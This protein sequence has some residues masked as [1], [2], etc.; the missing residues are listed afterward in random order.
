MQ[1]SQT[2][3]ITVD[4][5][6][7]LLGPDARVSP[8]NLAALQAAAAAG[9][10][11]VVATGRR[12]TYALHVLREIGMPVQTVM[13]TSNGAVVRTLAGAPIERT[14]MPNETARWLCGHIGEFR[15]ALVITFDKLLPDGEDAKGSL[16]VEELEDL[17]ASIGNWIRSNERYL[18]RV[19]P[20]EDALNGDPPIQMML[21][22]TVERMRRAELRMLED[23]RIHAVGETRPDSL[24]TLNRT[25][26]ADRDLSLLDILPAGCSKGNALL[27]L[28]ASHNIAPHEIMAIGDNYN[29]LS[30]LE[31]VGRPVLMGNAP[32]DLQ[33]VALQR[34]W[35]ITASNEIDGVA[36][37][38][39]ETFP[40]LDP[41]P[42]TAATA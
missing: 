20:I 18:E 31:V 16:V 6:G 14:F 27:R 30:M 39:Y 37:A 1:H 15:N 26:Y 4:L 42:L 11:I 41:E 24:L 34:N 35:H 9:I 8:R 3:M 40:E 2:R 29:D 28:A 5:D 22:G 23:P 36:E 25:E 17:T 12:H 19:T 13:I 10:H 7:T 32:L 38:I 21:C 33:A